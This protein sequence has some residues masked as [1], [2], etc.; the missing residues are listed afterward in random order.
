MCINSNCDDST[1]MDIG[2]VYPNRAADVQRDEILTSGQAENTSDS[3]MAPVYG[4]PSPMNAQMQIPDIRMKQPIP[5]AMMM[6]VY[7]GPE[8]ISSMQMSQ[9]IQ[10]ISPAIDSN[11]EDCEICPA[12]GATNPV[13]T[14]FC[15]NCG[16]VV[17]KDGSI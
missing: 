1:D 10:P 3:M 2:G 15:F 9:N 13:D 6:M 8:S 17:K 11:D 12:C 14:K 5:P 7:A 4:G 16:S